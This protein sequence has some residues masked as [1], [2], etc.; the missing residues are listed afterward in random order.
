MLTQ[1]APQSVI[2]GSG[3]YVLCLLNQPVISAQTLLSLWNSS[4]YRLTVDGGTNVWA[5]IAS[6]LFGFVCVF[7]QVH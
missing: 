1:W 5:E 6:S 7:A 2:A 4:V 3:R